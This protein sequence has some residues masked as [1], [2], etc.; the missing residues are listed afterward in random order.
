MQLVSGWLITVE[1]ILGFYG[2][3]SAKITC[4][5]LSVWAIRKKGDVDYPLDSLGHVIR[6]SVVVIGFILARAPGPKY[7]RLSSLLVGMVFLCWPNCAYHLA[8]LSRRGKS[9]NSA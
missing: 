7:F 3:F 2:A 8:R 6:W 9:S 5:W 1:N 4:I